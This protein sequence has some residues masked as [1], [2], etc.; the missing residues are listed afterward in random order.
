MIIGGF[1]IAFI[2]GWLH[3]LVTTAALPGMAFAGYLYAYV[4]QNM[5]IMKSEAY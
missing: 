1:I 5:N 3:C 4:L 2:R